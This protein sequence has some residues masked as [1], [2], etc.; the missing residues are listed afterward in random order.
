MDPS[1]NKEI[2]RRSFLTLGSSTL[3][4]AGL[5]ASYGTFV[6]YS[7]RFLYPAKD[8]LKA[9]MYLARAADIKK[10]DSIAYKAPTGETILVAKQGEGNSEINFIALGSTCPH[11]G[12]QVHWEKNNDRF[13]CP[14]HN[15]VFNPKGVAVSGPPADANQSLPKYP[16][17][18]ESGNLFIE[19]PVEKI[20]TT[21]WLP[22]KKERLV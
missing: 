7:A 21:P 8:R 22:V 19:V 3:A 2:D 12:C 10:G 5:A 11:L 13:F 15:G 20:A 1:Q 9:W 14:C 17:K 18:I 6:A 4:L 16:L